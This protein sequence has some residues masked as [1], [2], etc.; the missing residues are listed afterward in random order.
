MR[1][2]A[3]SS[4]PSS[5]V[6]A[7]ERA[8]EPECR[9][10]AGRSGLGE[11]RQQPMHGDRLGL[12]AQRHVAGRLE[13][14]A[15]PRERL[16]RPRNQ[17]RARRRHRPTAGRPYSRC[18]RSRRRRRQRRAEVAGDDRPGMD[19]DVQVTGWPRRAAHASLRAAPRRQH[20]QRGVEGPLRIVL[21]R[22]RR[23]KQGQHGI[24]HE[25]RRRNPSLR[26]MAWASDSNSAFWKART[27]SGSSRS[28]S[29]VN[30][31]RSAKRTVTC[32]RSASAC[33]TWGCR[34]GR[35]A[36]RSAART[37]GEVRLA[38]KAAAHAGNRLRRPQRGQKAKSAKISKPQLAQVIDRLMKPCRTADTIAQA[39]R[40]TVVPAI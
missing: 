34:R 36:R 7:D 1:S 38:G 33:G 2:K 22:D 24:A 29:E 11:H 3:A 18:R 5:S 30:P 13:G 9:E 25:L 32:R 6:A 31:E 12:A 37:E 19:G 39:E 15:M 16:G 10:T 27:S 26:V 20:V 23:A 8:G 4:W 14:E 21:V 35:L 28:E 40:W 17:D